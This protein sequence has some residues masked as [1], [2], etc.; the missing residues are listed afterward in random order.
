MHS[1]LARHLELDS[2]GVFAERVTD[3]VAPG[4]S[5]VIAEPMDFATIEQKIAGGN[6]EGSIKSFARDLT[7]IFDNAMS[8]NEDGSAVHELAKQLKGSMA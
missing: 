2:F 5:E 6:Y 1:V 3:D 7:L 4:Y 8:Y